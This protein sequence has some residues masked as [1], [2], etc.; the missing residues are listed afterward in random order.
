MQF[1]TKLKGLQK[2][3]DCEATK[4]LQVNIGGHFGTHMW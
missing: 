3:E 1:K 2:Q 4:L